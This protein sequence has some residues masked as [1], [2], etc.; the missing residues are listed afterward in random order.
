LK[1][2]LTN[3]IASLFLVLMFSTQF[4]CV[5]EI[6]KKNYLNLADSVDYVGAETCKSCHYDKHKTFSHTGMGLSFG[7]A[8]RTKSSATFH[9]DSVLYDAHSD[10][11]YHPL[12]KEDSLLVNEYRIANG[13]TV[14]KRTESAAYIIGSGQH[15][16]SHISNENGYLHQLPFTYYT[17]EGRLDLPP[18][19]EGGFNTRFNRKIGLECMS[20]HNSLPKFVLGSENKFEEVPLGISCERCHGPGEIHVSEKMK[21][22]LVDTSKFIDYT[23]VNPGKLSPDLQ[24]DLCSRCHLQGNTVLEEDKS[25][26]DFKPGMKL[27]DVMTVFLPRFKDDERFIMASHVDRLKMSQCFIKSND[28]LTCITCHN[29]HLSI[30]ATPKVVYK[31]ACYSCHSDLKEH[32]NEQG[33]DCVSCHMPKSGSTDIPHVTVTDHKIAITQHMSLSESKSVKEFIGLYC[34][35]NS[36]PSD[37]T[38]LRAYLQQYEKFE[39]ENYYL[40]SAFVYLSKIPLEMCTSEWIKFYFFSLD[41]NGLVNWFER[42][43]FESRS[44]QLNKRS[45]TNDDAWSWYR[46]GESYYK[47]KNYEKASV[48]F[49]QASLLAPFHLEIQNKFGMALLKCNRLKEAQKVF[50]FVRL[51]NPNFEKV[52]ANY[53]YLYTILGEFDLALIMYEKGIALNPDIVQLWMNLAAYYLHFQNI[54][55][56]QNSLSQVLRIKPNHKRAQQLLNQIK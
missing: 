12:W 36:S 34:V 5:Q 38:I 35:N 56:A 45:Y 6:P 32:E 14:H 18:G 51:E 20:C 54:E 26:F 17:Q 21:G 16:N 1:Y 47:T 37:L 19:F 55:S 53:G 40:D 11:Y 10:L 27:D 13:D 15:T 49:E 4:S 43:S 24:F 46:V 52:Y 2:R 39:K 31:N 50:E 23:I 28:E 22:I 30:N 8:N 9:K 41:F 44:N 25:F 42:A 29:P 3:S 48:C 33:D 7:L